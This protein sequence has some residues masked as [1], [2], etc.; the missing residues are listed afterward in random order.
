MAEEQTDDR[1]AAIE[2]AFDKDETEDN[3]PVAI[4]PDPEPDPAPEAEPPATDGVP[5]EPETETEPGPP[6]SIPEPPADP[7]LAPETPPEP[8]SES[9]AEEYVA[10]VG[11]RGAAKQHWTELP[12]EVQ[13]E[14]NKR[15]KEIS[16]AMR[17]A[18]EA[19]QFQSQFDQAVDPFK[20]LIASRGVDP[21]TATQAMLRTH[22]ALTLGTP[23]QKAE[24]I[25]KAVAEYG[26][27]IDQLAAALDGAE[28]GQAPAGGNGGIDPA[29]QQYLDA[30]LA[31]VRQLMG[32]L[33][34]NQQQQ[35]QQATEWA[36]TTMEQFAGNPENIFFEDVRED[37]GDLMELAARRGRE[38]SIQDAYKQAVLSN[39]ELAP[40]YQKRQAAQ[41]VPARQTAAE[42]RAAAASS[43]APSAQPATPSEPKDRREAL[44]QAW[45]AAVAKG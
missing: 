41:D 39:P 10:P 45:D 15:E 5:P 1:R 17:E 32:G 28:P 34:Q 27:D 13:A 11:W 42:R 26:I 4:A 22:A 19:K 14:V 9:G 31:P 33:Q 24:T 30:Q 44:E 29:M 16:G 7:A 36:A 40:L 6:D 21:L 8:A 37:M 35:Q 43:I 3:S 18:A 20:G 25:A 12:K 38:M 2:A 23:A